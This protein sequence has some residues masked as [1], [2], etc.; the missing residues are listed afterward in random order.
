M[1]RE[2]VPM[3]DQTMTKEQFLDLM[4]NAFQSVVFGTVD[5]NGDPHTNVADLE[6]KDGNKLI[7]ATS[8]KKAFYNRL[9]AH[10]RISITA[11]KGE[12]TMDSVGMILDGTVKE[13][14][15]GYLDQI[16]A[17]HP[18][19][20]S[21]SQNKNEHRNMLRTFAIYPEYGSVYDLRQQPIFQKAFRF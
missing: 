15:N 9:K 12:E 11:L 3:L 14:D 4:V 21:I 5:E 20:Q 8:Y 7:F 18:E 16:F 17:K 1:M 2:K 6:L 10:P 19:M 13:E